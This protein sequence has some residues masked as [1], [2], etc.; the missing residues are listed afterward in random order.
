MFTVNIL[1]LHLYNTRDKNLRAS[2]LALGTDPDVAVDWGIRT[3][4]D[5]L[6][7]ADV[8]KGIFTKYRAGVQVC[9]HKATEA[10]K[11]LMQKK[12][13]ILAALRNKTMFKASTE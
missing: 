13:F 3:Y 7:N 8:C 2:D 9:C 12:H 11:S 4:V 1:K 6:L 5:G 10:R